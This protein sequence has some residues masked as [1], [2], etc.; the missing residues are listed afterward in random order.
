MALI[1]HVKSCIKEGYKEL[2]Q[3]FDGNWTE[4]VSIDKVKQHSRNYA[5]KQLSWFNR[6]KDIHWIDLSDDAID[7][8][9]EVQQLLL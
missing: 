6:D 9:K 1:V 8:I 4:S 7:V 3:Y 5:R 2:F